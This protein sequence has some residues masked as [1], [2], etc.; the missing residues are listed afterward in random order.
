MQFQ[1]LVKV[2]DKDGIRDVEY[3][4]GKQVYSA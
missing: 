1:V 4:D 2:I 3:D